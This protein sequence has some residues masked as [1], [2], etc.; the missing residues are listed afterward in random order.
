MDQPAMGPSTPVHQFVLRISVIA[1]SL[2]VALPGRAQSRVVTTPAA[3]LS[4]PS[5]KAVGSIHPGT[6]VRVIETRGAYAKVT[7]DGFVERAR[8]SAQRGNASPRVGNRAAVVR[9][10]G[11]T[12][13]KSVASLDA[14]TTV[15]VAS[16]NAPTG[17]AK[18][19]RDGWILK[20]SL[21]RASSETARSSNSG[22]RT[23]ASS[24]SSGAARKASGGEVAASARP[25]QGSTP[26]GPVH[27]GA[28]STAPVA[29]GPVA[30]SALTPTGNIALRAA[31]DAKALATV[32]QGATLTPLARDRGWVRVRLEGWVPE[33]DVAPADTSIRTGVSAADLRADPVGNRGKLV[34]WSVQILARQKADVLRKD[35]APDETYLLARGPYEENAL[36]YLVVPPS[37]LVMTKSIPELSQAMIT[38]RV[39]TGRSDLVG[40]PILDLLTITPRK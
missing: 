29:R 7:I 15:A 16:G 36:L 14:G 17:W 11:A 3:V 22:G 25:P 32:V 8:L 4:S 38:A 9:A 6:T 30:D 18:V 13:A 34:R 28:T 37:L 2:A 23:T 40:V 19:S 39:R 33:R 24:K 35:L 21:D 31:P 1:L 20:S 27:A 12:T 26:S 5:G 10:R